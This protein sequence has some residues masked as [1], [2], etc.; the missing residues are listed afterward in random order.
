MYK[1]G[2]VLLSWCC[3]GLA[4]ADPVR[5]VAA[6]NFYA[7]LAAEIGGKQ[8][9]VQSIINNPAADPHLFATSPSVSKALAQAQII[10]YNGADY[11][12]W[13]RQMLA[14][15][16]LRKVIVINVA[17]LLGVKSGQNPHL[18]YKPET[19]PVLAKVLANKISQLSAPQRAIFMANLAQFLTANQRVQQAI[20]QAKRRYTGTMVAA[21]E[22]VYN[23]MTEALGLRMEG[24]DFQWKIMNDSEPSPK[25]IANF[26]ALIHEKK[27]KILF[28][29]N[30]VTDPLTQKMQDLAHQAQIP[31]IG[32]SETLPKNISINNW[33]ALELAATTA[34]LAVNR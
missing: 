20:F 5:I 7:E 4:V 6:E 16:D 32:I 18:W 27:V 2:I 19:F 9:Q 22:P 13:M 17:D 14:P 11:D 3:V 34:A 30:Q 25:M 24:L 31:V 29:N 23:Y 10:I 28:Y 33:L 26:Q 21:T 1:I 15:L 8:V 12:N